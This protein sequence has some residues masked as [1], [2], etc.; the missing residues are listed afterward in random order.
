MPGQRT[1]CVVCSNAKQELLPTRYIHVVFTLPREL[2]AAGVAEQARS[3]QPAVSRQCRTLLTIAR[4][5]KHLGAEIGF[6][7]VLHTWG[8]ETHAEPSLMMPGI[9][10]SFIFSE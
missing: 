7:T 10:I 5:P 4:D 6:F 1:R 3:L 9:I 2:A 8:P